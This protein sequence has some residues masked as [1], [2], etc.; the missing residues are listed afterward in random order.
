MSLSHLAN[1]H[2]TKQ[3]FKTITAKAFQAGLAKFI[4]K[5]IRRSERST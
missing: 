4:I 2:K 5:T 3:Q 1:I